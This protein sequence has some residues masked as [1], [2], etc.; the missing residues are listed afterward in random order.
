[1][2]EKLNVNLAAT[3]YWRASY[4]EKKG[5][6]NRSAFPQRA[7]TLFFAGHSARVLK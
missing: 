6:G 7:Q 5:I 4:R 2:K 1:M 3:P